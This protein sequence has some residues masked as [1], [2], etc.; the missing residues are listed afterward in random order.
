[1]SSDIQYTPGRSGVHRQNR[2]LRES[3]SHAVVASAP[4]RGELIPVVSLL[5]IAATILWLCIR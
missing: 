5:A 3:G 2:V 4:V 1:M